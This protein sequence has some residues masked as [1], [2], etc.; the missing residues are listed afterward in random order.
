MHDIDRILTEVEPETD[1]FETDQFEFTEEVEQ[2][3]INPTSP[4]SEVEEMELAA[5]VLGITDEAELDQFLGNLFKRA[6]R[7]LKKVGSFVGR[8]ARPLGSVLKGLAKKFLPMAAGAAGTYFGGPAGGTVGTSIGSAISQALETELEGLN[9]ED[10]EFE[11]ARRFVRL[12]GAAAQQ[13]ALAPPGADPAAA[14]RAV[15]LKAARQQL[16]QFSRLIASPTA[17]PVAAT[18]PPVAVTVPPVAATAPPVASS[19]VGGR[20]IRRGNK[21]VLLGA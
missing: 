2:G 9:P 15:L 10:R 12:A 3:E 18:A 16:P 21:I 17:S 19:R 14:A 6:W 1:A 20:W 5:E 11:V 4:F 13:A 7:G 8:I